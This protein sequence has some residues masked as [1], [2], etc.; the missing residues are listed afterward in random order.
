M[1]SYGAVSTPYPTAISA[2]QGRQKNS[3]I[4]LRQHHSYV[5]L[6]NFPA[7]LRKRARAVRKHVCV[8]NDA[9]VTSGGQKKQSL[10][11]QLKMLV[12]EDA[13]K[14]EPEPRRSALDQQLDFLVGNESD[15]VRAVKREET[16]QTI[17]DQKPSYSTPVTDENDDAIEMPFMKANFW[18]GSAVAL[19]LLTVLT[20]VFFVIV[21]GNANY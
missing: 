11:E 12:E 18:V 19:C 8:S 7:A 17:A 21:F 6:F 10:D 3:P 16:R 15:K 5:S 20:N 13:Q 9:K 14:S 1:R 2:Q 4:Q